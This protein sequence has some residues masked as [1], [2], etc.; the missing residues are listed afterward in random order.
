MLSA[1]LGPGDVT[2]LKKTKE[3]GKRGNQTTYF[4]L[5][6][7]SETFNGFVKELE[8]L[9]YDEQHMEAIP[10]ILWNLGYTNSDDPGP[11]IDGLLAQPSN[12]NPIFFSDYPGRSGLSTSSRHMLPTISNQQD[13]DASQFFRQEAAHT[14][15]QPEGQG[16]ALLS[17]ASHHV[18]SA[19][20]QQDL[21]G[22]KIFRQEAAYIL[23]QG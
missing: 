18:P 13:L 14:L 1:A 6:W 2:E 21:N 19:G 16:L 12:V 7:Y 4:S 8:K 10:K 22:S 9:W 20:G 11:I 23:G 3:R 5:E 15:G 17:T